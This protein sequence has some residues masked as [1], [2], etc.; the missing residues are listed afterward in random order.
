LQPPAF[1]DADVIDRAELKDSRGLSFKEHKRSLTPRWARVWIDIGAGYLVIA[2]T[3]VALVQLEDRLPRLVPLWIVLGAMVFGYTIAFVQLFLHEA[4][5]FNIAPGR[6]LNDVLA[7]VFLGSMIGMDIEPYRTVHFDHHR[8]LGTPLDTERNYFTALNAKFIVQSL[9]GVTLLTTV[10]RRRDSARAGQE[11]AAAATTAR[12][13]A[14]WRRPVMLLAGLL[15]NLAVVVLAWRGGHWALAIAWPLGMGCFHP[16]VNATRQI[17]EHRDFNAKSSIDYR[18]T[19]HGPMTRMFGTGPM[20][21]TMGGAG[22]N[23]HLLHH[24]EPQISYTRLRDLERFVLDTPAADVFRR[25]TTT[26]A[27]AFA[28]LMRAE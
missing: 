11:K 12:T 4:A 6:G 10:M 22:F 20:A 1:P 14:G 26:Y 5:H 28:R 27:R 3:M 17:L 7:N 2:G 15:I 8:Y 9:T 13:A 16:F 21:S 23:R 18:Q 24:W 25:Q 19:P